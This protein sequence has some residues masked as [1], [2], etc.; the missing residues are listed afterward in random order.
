[1]E[2]I[3]RDR[4]NI[5]DLALQLFGDISFASKIITDNDLTWSAPLSAGT[6]LIINNEGLGNEDLKNFF[7]QRNAFVQNGAVINPNNEAPYTFDN[8]LITWDSTII[9]WDQI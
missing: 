1:M 7:A 3:V 2:Y 4:Q 9:T 5:F 8:N 6:V